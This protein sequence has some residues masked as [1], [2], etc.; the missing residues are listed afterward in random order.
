MHFDIAK[1]TVFLARHGSHAYGTSLPTSDIDTKGFAVSPKNFVL[2]FAYSFEQHQQM[3]PEDKVVYDIRKFCNLAADCNPNIIEVLFVDDSDV[4]FQHPAGRLIRENR[5]LFLS[6]KARHTFSG[7]AVSQ[8]KRIRTHRGYLLNPPDHKPTRK[9]YGLSTEMKIT[10]D[11]MGAFDKMAAEGMAGDANVMDLVAKEKKYKA[12]LDAWNSHERWKTDRNQKRAALEAQHGYDC[13]L[14]DTEFLTESGWKRY[15]DIPDDARVGTLNPRT[16]RIE[17]Q[18]F[19]ERVAKPFDGEIAVLHPQHSNCAVTMNHR[20]LVSPAHRSKT[21][22]FSWEFAADRAD[23]TLRPLRD[24][25]ADRRSGFHTRLTADATEVEYPVSDD[26]L[27][28]LGC[29]VTEGCVGKRLADGSASV[30]RISQKVGGR[31]QPYMDGLM[32]KFPDAIRRYA[33]THQADEHRSAACD[34]HVWTIADRTRAGWVER[35]CGVGSASLRLPDWTR[36][37]SRRQVDLLLEVMV[38]GDGTER[39]H[40]RVYYT[41]SKQLA[42]DVQV[43][44]VSSGIVSQVWGPYVYEGGKGPMYQVYVGDRR[45]A[46]HVRLAPDSQSLDLLRMTGARIVCFTVPNEILVTRREG[47]IA[48]HG[49]TKHGMHLVRL[50]RMCREILEG[51]GVIVRRPDAKELLAIRAGEWPYERLVEWAEQQDAEMQTLY[52]ESTLRHAPDVA[53]LNELC[54]EAQEIFWRST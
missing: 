20:M 41:S 43:M 14:D 23:W 22:G 30:L 49:N 36:E 37:L 40:S 10:P 29:Y 32:V 24:L 2:G 51:Q 6:K 5:D 19:T 17:Y 1:H 31:Q 47:K 54:V 18:G 13:Y 35:C 42:D 12:A 52:K 15:D 28:L 27:V 9:E 34:E 39:E 4:L 7:Y 3:E 53:K 26:D 46:A 44:C 45:I 8:L 16:G 48:I 25:L 50:L 38:A 11:M 21:N 33:Y